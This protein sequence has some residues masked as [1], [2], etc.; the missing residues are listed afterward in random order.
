MS[1]SYFSNPTKET[2]HLKL[3]N[4]M[5]FIFNNQQH[6]EIDKS[7]ANAIRRTILSE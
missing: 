3:D 6:P 2:P 5:E 1:K 7:M 4:N